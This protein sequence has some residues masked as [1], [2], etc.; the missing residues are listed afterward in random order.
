[1]NGENGKLS[2]Y[3]NGGQALFFLSSGKQIIHLSGLFLWNTRGYNYKPCRRKSRT[4]EGIN[5]NLTG[6]SPVDCRVFGFLHE[7][8]RF[9]ARGLTEFE[10]EKR[11]RR[12]PVMK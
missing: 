9:E 2:V 7:D 3:N 5:E 4:L 10:G 11:K 6:F 8:S 12:F 1:M